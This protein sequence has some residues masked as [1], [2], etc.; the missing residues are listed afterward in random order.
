MSSER[1]SVPNTAPGFLANQIRLSPLSSRN[2]R[3]SASSRAASSSLQA[4]PARGFTVQGHFRIRSRGLSD[5]TDTSPAVEVILLHPISRGRLPLR[6]P[7]GPRLF[8]GVGE[9]PKDPQDGGGVWLMHPT[10]VFAVSYVQRVMGS[11]LDAPALLFE[12]QPLLA[13]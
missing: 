11:I 6:P 4:V 10:L 13:G 1:H 5:K 3:S 12:V 9:A 7:F 2:H 8:E